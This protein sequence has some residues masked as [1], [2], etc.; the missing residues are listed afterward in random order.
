MSWSAFVTIDRNAFLYRKCYN[1]MM[2]TILD[3]FKYRW[4]MNRL[5]KLNIFPQKNYN[6]KVFTSE[7]LVK[8]YSHKKVILVYEIRLRWVL[9]DV[10]QT[11][12]RHSFKI[13]CGFRLH[14][15]MQFIHVHKKTTALMHRF[16]WNLHRLNKSK[17][18]YRIPNFTQTRQYTWKEQMLFSTPKVWPLLCHIAQNP[19]SLNKVLWTSTVPSFIQIRRKICKI[20]TTFNLQPS[21]NYGFQYTDVHENSQLLSGITCRSP[22]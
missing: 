21:G 8:L 1:D 6:K 19:Q 22:R 11:L 7:K 2:F 18:R 10:V 16:S 17:C 3:T 20:L 15:G 9:C 13:S 14:K 4:W 5:Q 12:P